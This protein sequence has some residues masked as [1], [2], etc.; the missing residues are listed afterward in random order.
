MNMNM[1][2]N[3]NEHEHKHK[4]EP[5]FPSSVYIPDPETCS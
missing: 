3:K 1:N 2:M 5:V 4:H